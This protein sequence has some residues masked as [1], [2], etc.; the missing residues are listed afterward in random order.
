MSTASVEAPPPVDLLLGPLRLPA[1]FDYPTRELQTHPGERFSLTDP[2]WRPEPGLISRRTRIAS[3]GSCFAG[4]IKRW[5]FFR[6]YCYIQAEE[7]PGTENGSARFGQVYS[8]A[9]LR[10]IFEFAYDRFDPI[11]RYW[12]YDDRLADPYR[13]RIVWPDEAAAETE[14]AAHATAVRRVV[15]GSDVLICTLGLCEVW[16]HREDGATFWRLPLDYDPGRHEFHVQSVGEIVD[17]LELLWM[18]LRARNPS[19]RL[20][21]TLSPVPLHQTFREMS[22]AAADTASKARLRTAIDEFT[23]RHPE[24]IYFPAFEIVR[25]LESNPW[26]DDRRHVRPETVDRVMSVFLR[27]YGE[28]GAFDSQDYLRSIA[29]AD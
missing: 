16:R 12:R 29:S 15:E 3:V 14:R 2:V 4:E 22:L 19:L 27:N 26:R 7:G 20:V 25:E 23:T 9:S 5:L 13:S 21:L 10:Q 8:S 18:L 6:D 1:N 17:D 28:S 24:V 11:E